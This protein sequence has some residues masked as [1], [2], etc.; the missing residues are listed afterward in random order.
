MLSLK[1]S[2]SGVRKLLHVPLIIVLSVML[3]SCG[4]GSDGRNI[5][6]DGIKGPTVQLIQ[7]NLLI[8]FVFEN[9]VVQGGLRYAIPEYQNSYVEISPDLQS[10]GTLMAFSIALDDVLNGDL[11]TLDPQTLP[12]GRA[13]PGVASGSLP[14]VAFTIEDWNDISLYIGPDV[15]GVF[16]PVDL[17]MQGSM[18]TFRYYTEGTRTGNISLVG[19]D[20]NGENA[21]VLLMLDMKS[22]TKSRLEKI[23]AKY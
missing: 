18:L 6:I 22:R 3:T 13:L 7:D 12:G 10:G 15:Y 5:E 9:L 11:D 20:S 8:S 23:A 16:I 17:N 14:A 1:T 19:E 21:G 2:C 4:D